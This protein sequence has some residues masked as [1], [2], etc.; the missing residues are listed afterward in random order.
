MLT[1]RRI[2]Q[3]KLETRKKI[4]SFIDSFFKEAFT[5]LRKI[6]VSQWAEEYR[7]LSPE[8]CSTPGKFSHEGFEYL[9]GFED[10]FTNPKIKKISAYKSAQTG[11]TVAMLNMIGTTIMFDPGPWL[12]GYPT[13]TS[14]K[15]FS[16]RKLSPMIRDCRELSEL[17]G[18]PKKR[19]GTNSINEKDFPGM[20]ISMVGFGSANNLASQSIRYL[21]IDEADRIPYITIN[22]GDPCE[23]AEKRTQ[24]FQDNSKIIYI[25][26]PTIKD[27]SRIERLFLE[28]DQRYYFMPCPECGQKVVY[29]FEHFKFEYDKATKKHFD[30][31]FLCPFC[32][33]KV[34][35]NKKAWMVRNGEWI[36]TVPEIQD[37]AGFAINEFYS[38]LSTWNGIIKDFLKKKDKPAEFQ[39]FINLT[40][41]EV[42]EDKTMKKL[43]TNGLIARCED[44]GPS[45]PK[46]IALLTAGVDVQDDRL[47]L[48]LLGW[49]VSNEIWVID[50][51]VFW[52]D[53]SQN[54][55]WN[56]LT[57][58]LTK[59]FPTYNNVNL[60]ISAVCIDAMGHHTQ[61]VY[62]YCSGKD[63][64]TT[65]IFAIHGK[66]GVG[67]PVIN[68][69]SES[70]YNGRKYKSKTVG[71]DGAKE[72]IYSWLS[73]CDIGANYIHFPKQF[74]VDKSTLI[75]EP[76]DIEFFEQLTAEKLIKKYYKGVEKREWVKRRA[77]NEILDTFVY[78]YAAYVSMG[79]DDEIIRG[80]L[81]IIEDYNDQPEEKKPAEKISQSKQNWVKMG[82]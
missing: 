54:L 56:L 17:V 40:L 73:N 44:Y 55:I 8:D 52:G 77:R 78:A 27:I 15:K 50:H 5:P 48:L 64:G 4:I 70:E 66:A 9:I 47:E 51:Q 65:R 61:Q 10:A 81:E 14:V 26:T 2:F 32:E 35:E 36:P 37:H 62:D 12:I 79:I 57:Y 74:K 34:Y 13:D 11:F 3:Q 33:K 58:Y 20:S 41:G 75:G 6:S 31:H 60:R 30:L 21:C 42:W 63:I 72:Q 45:L 38:P 25:S 67:L 46:G 68:M 49:G 23:V 76:I 71:V 18:D 7:V 82:L 29:K 16:N 80:N 24:G 1:S 39:A 43:D 19:D 59:N 28:S 69:S 53:P 22:E